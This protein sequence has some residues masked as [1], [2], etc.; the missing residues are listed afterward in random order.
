MHF[1]H[2]RLKNYNLVFINQNKI[3]IENFA[4]A[5]MQRKA[6]AVHASI[7]KFN[8]IRKTCIACG[9]AWCR[10]WPYWNFN[11]A[12]LCIKSVQLFLPWKFQCQWKMPPILASIHIRSHSC[13]VMCAD[14][15]GVFFH[16]VT[17]KQFTPS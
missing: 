16:W 5:N 11:Q 12:R 4:S 14:I 6:L 1:K 17:V 8:K 9:I 13:M 15:S 2:K 7:M 10:A 3:Q